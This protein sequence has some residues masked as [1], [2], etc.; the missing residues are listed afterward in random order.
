[1][2]VWQNVVPHM[3][4]SRV[5]SPSDPKCRDCYVQLFAMYDSFVRIIINMYFTFQ[6]LARRLALTYGIELTKEPIR[7]AMINL[8]RYE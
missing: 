3:L 4:R 5:P 1:M 7:K 2:C 6:E 8:H